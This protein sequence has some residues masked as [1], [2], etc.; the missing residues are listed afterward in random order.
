M[1]SPTL[2]MSAIGGGG[3]RA[4]A[5]LKSEQQAEHLRVV[6]QKALAAAQALRDTSVRVIKMAGSA[7]AQTAG[8]LLEALRLMWQVIAALLQ[9]IARML[10]FKEK[11][12]ANEVDDR[13]KSTNR[14]QPPAGD[15][16]LE[17]KANFVDAA[18]ADLVDKIK[19]AE[20]LP[21]NQRS[22]FLMALGAA[23]LTDKDAMFLEHVS[24]LESLKTAK[25]MD[26]M[27][28]NSLQ[29][30]AAAIDVLS[31]KLVA[32][33]ATRAELA[34]EFAKDFAPP[35]NTD[36]LVAMLKQ[37]PSN[38][39]EKDEKVSALLSADEKVASLTA[40]LSVVRETMNAV[41]NVAYQSKLDLAPHREL[42]ARIVGADW[43]QVAIDDVSEQAKP[44]AA[45]NESPTS[46]AAKTQTSELIAR[47]QSSSILASAAPSQEEAE[48]LAASFMTP[49]QS[50]EAAVSAGPLSFAD[51]LRAL[52]ERAAK[53][54]SDGDA[55]QYE[56]DDDGEP[57]EAMR[58]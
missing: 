34:A 49:A 22:A 40:S 35:L 46:T 51:R 6:S 32:A 1:N 50:S 55:P 15:S 10:G 27:V 29:K 26:A 7:T 11:A 48:S 37:Q 17:D 2:A 53:A 41:L 3:P 25:D 30:S 39:D 57:R 21:A 52:N 23:G 36:D 47:V 38:A 8:M 20:T 9:R 33:Q 12:V 28:V 19:A 58:A 24:S 56:H 5:A 45:A 42:I 18:S 13:E 16:S 14:V 4:R 43:E 31:S 44:L 54:T